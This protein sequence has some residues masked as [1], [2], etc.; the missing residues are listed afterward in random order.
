M[1]D[2]VLRSLM[3]KLLVKQVLFTRQNAVMLIDHGQVKKSII[4][5]KL[6][7]AKLRSGRLQALELQQFLHQPLEPQEPSQR[8]FHVREKVICSLFAFAKKNI[9]YHYIW[10]PVYVH[11]P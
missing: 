10:V 9:I 4:S 2:I 1:L 6:L 3:L 8:G 5:P 11:V 7:G